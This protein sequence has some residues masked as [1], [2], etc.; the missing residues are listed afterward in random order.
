MVCH[1]FVVPARVCSGTVLRCMPSIR[2]FDVSW[3][4]FSM[5]SQMPVQW[6]HA[7]NRRVLSSRLGQRGP[8]QSHRHLP[9]GK[10]DWGHRFAFPDGGLSFAMA[11]I[12]SVLES[13]WGGGNMPPHVCLTTP[14]LAMHHPP[15]IRDPLPPY[16]V[17]WHQYNKP[18]DEDGSSWARGPTCIAMDRKSHPYVQ[19]EDTVA[20]AIAMQGGGGVWQGHAVNENRPLLSLS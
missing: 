8:R 7:D 3:A 12:V 18:Q 6:T 14:P 2:D 20:Q 5:S 9:H 1:T 11:T 16:L 19:G 17:T 10:A 15:P 4:A 13:C